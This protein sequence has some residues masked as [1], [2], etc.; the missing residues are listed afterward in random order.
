VVYV[1]KDRV[2][3][4]HSQQLL[5]NNDKATAIQA[6]IRDP[7][8]I[9]RRA[10]TREL[11][12]FDEPIGLLTLLVWHFIPDFDDPVGLLDRY[13]DRLAPGSHLALMHLTDDGKPQGLETVVDEMRRRGADEP[14]VRSH[15]QVVAMFAGFELVDPGVV[16]CAA[17]RPIGPGDFSPDIDANTLFYAGVG[18]RSA[19]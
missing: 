2:A 7:E 4:V 17:W 10:E 9:L 3:V 14:N 5:R 1:D 12:N 6:D 11:L 16:S 13:R 8:A 19:D 18:R 15:E